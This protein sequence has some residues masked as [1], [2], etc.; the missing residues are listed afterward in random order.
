M[1]RKIEGGIKEHQDLTRFTVS[2][3]DVAAKDQIDLMSRNWFSLVPGR[4]EPI[5]HK[6]VDQKT[7]M[8]ESVRITGSKEHGGIATIHDQDLLLFAISQWV[9]AQRLG[10]A[11]SR[12]IHFTP[13]QFFAWL[14]IAPHGTAYDRLKDALNRLKTTNIQTTVRAEI[15][16][17]TRNR[18]KQ[19]S[20]ITEWEI[21]EEQGEVRGIEVVLAEWLFESIQNFHVLTLDKRYFE[22]PGGVERWLYLYARKAT[23]G[24]AG[25]WKETFK[26]LYLKSASQQEY[27]HYASTLRKL[28]KKNE[29]PGVRLEKV[30]S[31]QGKDMLLME[32]TDKRLLAEKLP[33]ADREV[34]MALIE[35]TP[36]EEAWENVLEILNKHLGEATVNAWIRILNLVGY[37]DGTLTYRASTQFIVD[38]V[39]IQ[40]K[41]RL[42]QAWESLGY[43]LKAIR[44]EVKSSKKGSSSAVG[45]AKK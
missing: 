39:E 21:T 17:R 37:E 41:P 30:S 10:L 36:L 40:Y 42:M 13:Y 8:T 27:K 14:K 18:I 26:S 3:A 7:G 23:G 6:Y 45:S 22:I 25:I 28:I 38:T 20:W 24:G 31:V 43:D 2:A 32:R 9:D 12:R 5:D 19:F 29:L 1:G 35:K 11:T 44:F 16:K 15:G 33:A 34:Q 4:T